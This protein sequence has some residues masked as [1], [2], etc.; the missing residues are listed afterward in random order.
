MTDELHKA[1]AQKGVWRAGTET[2]I[3]L[4]GHT[5]TERYKR[6]VEM[7]KNAFDNKVP[8]T[9]LDRRRLLRAGQDPRRGGP[10][11]PQD[12]GRT[13][14]FPNADMLRAMTTNGYKMSETEKTRGPIKAGFFADMIAV[15]GNPLDESTRCRTCSS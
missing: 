7:L 14:A 6:T 12:R 11:V 9:L 15:A 8:L 5:T 4:T 13:P 1:M 2:P 10:R 3:T